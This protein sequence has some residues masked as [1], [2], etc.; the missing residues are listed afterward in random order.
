MGHPIRQDWIP[1]MHDDDRTV[2]LTGCLIFASIK[3][4]WWVKYTEYDRTILFSLA[5]D[6]T[7]VKIL[8]SVVMV[9]LYCNIPGTFAVR[10][11][12]MILSR[13]LSTST[14]QVIAATVGRAF[15]PDYFAPN[16]GLFFTSTA[17]YFII[18]IILSQV[19]RHL[20]YI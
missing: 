2:H 13:E 1:E 3:I 15:G 6:S 18:I 9:V 17:A 5:V 10:V 12:F 11:F 16:F 7:E 8:W 19:C 20:N 4:P 14:L